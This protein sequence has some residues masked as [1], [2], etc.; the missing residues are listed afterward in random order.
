MKKIGVN[1][2]QT[3]LELSLDIISQIDWSM[4]IKAIKIAPSLLMLRRA[5]SIST[6]SPES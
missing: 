6:G 1:I 2:R 4:E 3:D 5:A